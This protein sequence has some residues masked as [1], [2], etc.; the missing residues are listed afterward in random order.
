MEVS[1]HT[2]IHYL[3]ITAELDSYHLAEGSATREFTA[4][5]SPLTVQYSLQGG[6][7][8]RLR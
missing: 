5:C 4:Q 2:G 8:S 1:L 3:D 7:L 6:S